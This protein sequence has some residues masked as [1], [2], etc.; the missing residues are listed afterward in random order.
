M[1]VKLRSR[2]Y[3]ARDDSTFTHYFVESH[4]AQF[5]LIIL[6]MSV[7][8]LNISAFRVVNISDTLVSAILFKYRYRFRRFF[9]T[10]FEYRRY[11]L[12]LS[13]SILSPILSLSSSLSMK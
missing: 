10:R 2:S 5:G 3:N 11:F 1:H 6:D 7:E 8:I 4:S 12:T 13:T 9:C